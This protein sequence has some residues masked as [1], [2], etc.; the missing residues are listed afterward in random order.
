MFKEDEI[1][2]L[3]KHLDNNGKLIISSDLTEKQKERYQFINDLNID[4][5]SVLKRD[6]QVIDLG[7]EEPTSIA[8]SDYDEED[9]NDDT[10]VLDDD[11][12][13]YTTIKE[14]DNASIDN[15]DN[16]F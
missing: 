12:S 5:I 7:E 8:S 1:E 4:L 6:K 2:E 16:F 3:R 10:E 14:D 9:D 15:L 11:T 13:S